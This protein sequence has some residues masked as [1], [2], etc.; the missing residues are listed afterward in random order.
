MTA[1]NNNK[2]NYPTVLAIIFVAI[3]ALLATIAYF[4]PWFPKL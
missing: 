2:T 4:L 1:Q 3:I